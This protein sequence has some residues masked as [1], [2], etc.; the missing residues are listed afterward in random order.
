MQMTGLI[1]LLV[2]VAGTYLIWQARKEGLYW[3]RE[4]V[5]IFRKALTR[6]ESQIVNRDRQEA[7]TRGRRGTLRL[8][9]AISL[10]FLGQFLVLLDLAF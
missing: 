4:F 7:D 3:T 8:V 2:I 5:L 9:G 6:P 1:G 10:I